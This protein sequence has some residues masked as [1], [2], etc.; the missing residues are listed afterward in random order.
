MISGPLPQLLNKGLTSSPLLQLLKE[1]PMPRNHLFLPLLEEVKN[2]VLERS[3]AT[4]EDDCLELNQMFWHPRLRS[5]A[6]I[7]PSLPPTSPTWNS[8]VTM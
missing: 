1:F 5:R 6:V 7:P 4:S 2:V 8:G 3:F